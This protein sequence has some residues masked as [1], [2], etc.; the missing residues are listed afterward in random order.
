MLFPQSSDFVSHKT[1]L[2]G[3][4]NKGEIEKIHHLDN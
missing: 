1:R 3:C 2:C 4:L